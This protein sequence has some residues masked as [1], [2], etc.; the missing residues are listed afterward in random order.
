VFGRR[1]GGAAAHVDAGSRPAPADVAATDHVP[2]PDKAPT[3][4]LFPGPT[5]SHKEP[6]R[7]GAPGIAL[8]RPRSDESIEAI[9]GRLAPIIRK[10]IDYGEALR[11]S[12]ANLAIRIID[13]VED[14]ANA[15]GS[16]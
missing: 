8:S 12:R 1:Q 11:L 4:A 3:S 9:A 5:T 16:C 2:G 13:A 10:K 6:D 15:A 7:D 14:D